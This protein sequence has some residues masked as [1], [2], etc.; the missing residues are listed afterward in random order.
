MVKAR[1]EGNA[2][3]LEFV[4]A[5]SGSNLEDEIM[6]L[7]ER[8]DRT[9]VEQELSLRLLRHFAS[10]VRHQRFTNADILTARIEQKLETA[11]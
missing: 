10:S 1:R 7:S 2:I 9:S 11:H 5:G 4:T 8:P 6:L 3:E